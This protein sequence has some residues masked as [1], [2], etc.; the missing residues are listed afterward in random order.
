VL[1]L[2]KSGKEK[3][4][5]TN[6]ITFLCNIETISF[7]FR[8]SV[9]ECGGRGRIERVRFVFGV[10]ATGDTAFDSNDTSKCPRCAGDSKALL[11][12]KAVSAVAGTPNTK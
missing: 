6:G 1:H 8:R 12:S 4:L 3:F 10:P 5:I 9:L 11:Y 7:V 2:A